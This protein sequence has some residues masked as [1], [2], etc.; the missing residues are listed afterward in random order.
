MDLFGHIRWRSWRERIGFPAA[1]GM[2]R[3]WNTLLLFPFF[4][5][6]KWHI[7]E[8]STP[9]KCILINRLFYFNYLLLVSKLKPNF[10]PSHHISCISNLAE[11][12][13]TRNSSFYYYSPGTWIWYCE[14]VEIMGSRLVRG[15]SWFTLI[16]VCHF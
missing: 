8:G 2:S 1:C 9:N 15:W 6:P 11:H 10:S 14:T 3:V 7:F 12:F 16:L 13:F 5:N 4:T